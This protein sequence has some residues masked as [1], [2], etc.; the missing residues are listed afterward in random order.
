MVWV[1]VVKD[2]DDCAAK[3]EYVLRFFVFFG[4]CDI[5]L[6]LLLS[7]PHPSKKVFAMLVDS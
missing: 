2:V 4:V 3:C 1:F 5:L 7:F 6:L